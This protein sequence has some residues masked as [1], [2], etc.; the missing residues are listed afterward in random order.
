M[1]NRSGKSRNSKSNGRKVGMIL[2]A[3]IACALAAPEARAGDLHALIDPATL[4]AVANTT[5]GNGD[6]KAIYAVNGAGMNA[7]GTHQSDVANGKMWEAG[8]VSSTSPGSFKVNLGRVVQL[9]G[10]KI[11]NYNWGGYTTRGAKDMEIYYTDSSEIANATSQT[12]IGYI[13]S[14]WTKLKDSFVLPEALGNATYAGE[15]MITFEDVEAQWVVFVITSQWGGGYG[16]LSEVRFYEHIVKPVLGDVSLSRTDAATYSLTATED[17]NAADLSYILSDGETVTTNATQSVAEGGTATWSIAGLTANKT[18]QVSVLAVNSNGTD[19]KT[20]G[21]FYTGELTLGAATDANENGPV[22]GTVAVSRNDSSSFPLT[23]NYTIS[24][25]AAGAVEGTTWA[26]PE[27]VTIP[28]GETTGYLLVTPLVDA[29]VTEDVTVTVMLADGNYEIPASASATLDI[30]NLSVPSGYNTWIATADGLASVGSNWSAGSAPTASDNV[31]FDGRFSTANCEWDA[32]ATATVASWTQT[33]DYTG[34]VTFDTEFPDYEGATFTLFTVTGNCD[35]LGGKWSCRGNYNNYGVSAAAMETS[36][37]SRRWCLNVA[38][39]DAMT[40]AAG[41][42]LTATGKGY[43]YTSG[44]S[45][46][47]PAYGGYAYGGSTVPYGSI[48][49]PFDPGLGC[50]SQNDQRKK[51]SGIGGGAIKLTVTGSLTLGGSIV[52]LGTIDQNVARS[53]GTGGSI[54]IAASQI[55]GSGKIDA[56]APSAGLTSDQAVALGSGGRIA[57]YTQSPLAFPMANVS[58]SGSAYKGTTQGS[59]VKISGPGTIFVKDPT[60]T[61]GTLYVKQS[62]DVATSGNKWTGTPV[63]GDLSLDAVVLSGNAQLRIP[64]GTS[65]ALPSLSAVT[66]DN[67]IAGIAGVVC[68]GGTLNIGNGDQVLK[69]NVAF[70]SPTPFAFPADLTLESGAHLGRV[71]GAFAQELSHFDTNFTVSVAGNLTI[72]SGATAGASGCCAFTT[73]DN[74]QLAAHGGQSLWASISGYG[75][76]AFDSVLNPSMPGG[77]S[78]R[79]FRAG[80]VFRLMVGGELALNGTISSDGTGARGNGDTTDKQAAPAG[81]SLNL[82]LGSL[83]GSGSITAQGGCGKYNYAGGAGGGRVAVRLTGN[84]S[85]FSD[86]WKTNITAYG[87]SFSGNNNSKASSAGTV[88]LQDASDGEAAGMVLIRNDLA[89]EAGAVNNKAV[90]LYPGKGVGCDAPEAFKKT[91][92]AVAGA[93]KVQLTDA[94]KIAGL[95]IDSD[96]LIDLN[97]KTLTVKSAKVNGV[98]LAPGTYTAESTVVIGEGSLGDYL[99]DTATGGALVV[100]GGGFSLKVR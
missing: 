5:S 51:I 73:T 64:A 91:D 56:S 20:V 50:L 6:R 29:S 97:G 9:N 74:A 76:N 38:V 31:L 36:R 21:I 24:S 48:E 22:A 39:G 95:T 54:W 47:A 44:S 13:R 59:V 66:T 93:A 2:A 61:H 68:D 89:L 40:V 10:I 45:K 43:G 52:S 12:P 16:G 82:S 28:A 70:A 63:M 41:A 90:T 67:T 7:D 8:G 55:S 26:A 96:S 92:L 57:L 11:W 42:T 78:Y 87:V 79:G 72:P 53:S 15:D 35:I 14:N 32:D 18:Y 49:Q 25:A 94:L 88:Y 85:T 84:G 23:L 30:A 60:Q 17:A 58:C 81:G 27:A 100:T 75:T 37:T 80:G 3:F 4:S 46:L 86:Y 19:E 62:R 71:G 34:T 33:A 77:S 1:A 69:S 99:V 83:T 65:L 98:K